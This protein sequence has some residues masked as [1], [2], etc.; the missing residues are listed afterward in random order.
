MREAHEEMLEHFERPEAVYATQV[1]CMMASRTPHIQYRALLNFGHLLAEFP[2]LIFFR[3][4]KSIVG[5][6]VLNCVRSW[7]T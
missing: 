7:R 1:H 6:A 4:V 2:Q 3:L 5:I